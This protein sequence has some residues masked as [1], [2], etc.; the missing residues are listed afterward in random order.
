[1]KIVSCPRFN[2]PYKSA[3]ISIL[4]I[5]CLT[6]QFLYYMTI[7]C[8]KFLPTH[9][10]P[11]FKKNKPMNNGYFGSIIQNF[12]GSRKQKQ[13]KFLYAMVYPVVTWLLVNLWLILGGSEK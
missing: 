6:G 2:N 11:T 3:A 8:E 13:T 1:M 12:F 5:P 10:I 4:N 9:D 7:F